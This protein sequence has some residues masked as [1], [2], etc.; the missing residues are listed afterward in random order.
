LIM[1]S[2]WTASDGVGVR[3]SQRTEVQ[4]KVDI[5]AY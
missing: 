1:P 4:S 3:S 2:G 5:L